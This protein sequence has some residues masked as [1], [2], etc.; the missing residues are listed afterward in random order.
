MMKKLDFHIN[1]FKKKTII[2]LVNE[3]TSNDE[4]KKAGASAVVTEVSMPMKDAAKLSIIL[5]TGMWFTS[6]LVGYQYADVITRPQQFCFETFR[7]IGAAFF[8]N[9]LL[10]TGLSR[11]VNSKAGG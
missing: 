5:A 11:I 6:F 10:L 9:F 2:R 8:T 7:F 3:S 4:T 1:P